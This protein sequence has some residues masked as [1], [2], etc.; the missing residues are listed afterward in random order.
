D[1][2]RGRVV[3][4]TDRIE[5]VLQAVTGYGL[6]DH[7]GPIRLQRFANVG[8]S[9]GRIAHVMQAIEARD[10]VEILAREILRKSHLE[11]RIIRD[12]VRFG[13]GARILDR[14][15]MEVVAGEL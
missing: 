1:H 13:M 10:E 11:P 8:C 4:T 15:R 2:G 5:I 14:A 12:A 3:E 9:T 7:P 6:D